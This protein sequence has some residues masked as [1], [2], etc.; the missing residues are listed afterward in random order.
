MSWRQ[1]FVFSKETAF[2]KGHDTAEM[3]GQW[4]QPPPGSK[5]SYTYT[6]EGQKLVQTG[7]RTWKEM[8]YGKVS[9]S[10]QWSF[11]LDYDYIEPFLFCFDKYTFI[12]DESTHGTH[13]FSRTDEGV[14]SSF[15]VRVKTLNRAVGGPGDMFED[16]EGCVVTSFKLSSSA[17]SSQIEVNLGGIYTDMSQ[18]TAGYAVGVL[19]R[20][21]YVHRPNNAVRY[22]C[23]YIGENAV[24]DVTSVS[25]QSKNSVSLAYSVLNPIA[26]SRY[27]VSTSNMFSCTIFSKDPSILRQRVYTGG[28]V[29][30]RS[31][32]WTKL[33]PLKEASFRSIT[34]GEDPDA[35]KITVDDVVVR[36]MGIREEGQTLYDVLD[37]TECRALTLE[38]TNKIP[39][40]MNLSRTEAGIYNTEV[41]KNGRPIITE[42]A[43]AILIPS[44]L[45][46]HFTNSSIYSG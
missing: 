20:L 33:A 16:L 4:Y 28:H 9:G 34:E 12:T 37:S 19:D 14:T 45:E 30:D 38:F 40:Q 13:R 31:T 1:S 23:L 6:R 44:G 46:G 41:Q 5:F 11:P 17:G 29:A 42:S 32:R 36:S 10:W 39:Y 26:R 24:A 25:V 18:G 15:T 21:D 8:A 3:L 35:M 2:G 22:T 7:Q 27:E 43:G